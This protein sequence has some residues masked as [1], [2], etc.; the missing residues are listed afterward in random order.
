MR[1]QSVKS[2]RREEKSEVKL[3]FS[4]C[5]IFLI[6]EEFL[7][8]FRVFVATPLSHAFV[9]SNKCDGKFVPFMFKA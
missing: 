7:K 4:P 6:D 3:T 2:E 5:S 9:S 1:T 8:S